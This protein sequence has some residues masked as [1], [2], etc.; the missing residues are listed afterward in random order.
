MSKSWRV[1]GQERKIMKFSAARVIELVEKWSHLL[2]DS[3]EPQRSTLACLL[4][5]QD[6]A[7][8]GLHVPSDVLEELF[9]T[10][11]EHE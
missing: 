8:R 7:A 11:T 6:E 5:N 9:S 4:E 1:E 2:G 3:T 10:P